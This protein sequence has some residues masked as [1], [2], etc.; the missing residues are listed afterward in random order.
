MLANYSRTKEEN[1]PALILPKYS[2]AATTPFPYAIA[3]IKSAALPPLPSW[4]SFAV[5][6]KSNP[7]PGFLHTIALGAPD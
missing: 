5:K 7:C 2:S 4:H 6:P 1:V 3:A